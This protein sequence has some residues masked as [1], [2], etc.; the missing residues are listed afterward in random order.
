MVGFHYGYGFSED[1]T[2][3]EDPP[4]VSSK[5]MLEGHPHVLFLP[6]KEN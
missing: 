3:L 4:R 5:V 1:P 2:Y 6:I